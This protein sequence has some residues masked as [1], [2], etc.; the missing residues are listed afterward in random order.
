MFTKNQLYDLHITKGLSINKI[1]KEHGISRYYIRK[2]LNE[3]NIQEQKHAFN[4][5]YKP[6]YF[7]CPDIAK[8]NEMLESNSTGPDIMKY[9]SITRVHLNH[10]QELYGFALKKQPHKKIIPSKKELVEL[11]SNGKSLVDISKLY[12]V[13]NVTVSNWF[14]KLG[15]EK[16]K[17]KDTQKITIE[18]VTKTKIKKYDYSYFPSNMKYRR[19][20]G[21]IQIQEYLKSLGFDFQP[22]R[23]ILSDGYEI[24]L[25]N[26]E[27]SLAIEF[28]G[29]WW[30][31]ELYK[32]RDY[33]WNKTKQCADKDIQLV[34]VFD[35]EWYNK[36]D[37]IKQFLRSKLGIF[38]RR[39]YARKC[40]VIELESKKPD[41]LTNHIQGY[42]NKVDIAFG[43]IHDDEL[44]GVVTYGMHHRGHD[45]MTLNRLCFKE[46]VQVIGGASKLIKT[47]L[48]V[49]DCPIVT[50]SDNRFST[51]AV[52]EKSGFSL[53][54]ELKPDYFYTN[55]SE[56]KP[57]QSMKKSVIGCPDNMTEH[58]YCNSLGWFRVFDSG[59]KRWQCKD[60]LH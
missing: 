10:W 21:E 45:V 12:D 28:N 57:K 38:D 13:S 7:E 24:D 56:I 48:S 53:D 18:K 36:Q 59:K 16:R 50:W 23:T 49:L 43:L 44:L 34:H 9:F 60:Y 40:K 6:S 8:L 3:Y 31:S 25:Y 33:H 5:K 20:T 55:G 17:H 32:D 14:K 27:H 2:L 19:S 30:H 52:Y 29:C 4:D 46:N 35:Y 51:G 11:Y 54:Q 37:Q 47:S 1:E 58:A 41:I 15:I 42:P 22:D 26:K 39:F